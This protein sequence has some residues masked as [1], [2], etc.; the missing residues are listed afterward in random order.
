MI[1]PALTDWPALTAI[2]DMWDDIEVTPPACRTAT[3]LPAQSPLLPA[4]I[5]TPSATA[6][7]GVP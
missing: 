4:Y 2:D 1:C 3:W 5:T 6:L 7:M